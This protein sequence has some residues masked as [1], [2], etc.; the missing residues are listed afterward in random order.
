M[1]GDDD[2]SRRMVRIS[3][4]VATVS[5]DEKVK[6]VAAGTSN[7]SVGVNGVTTTCVV[8]VTGGNADH[9]NADSNGNNG[10]QQLQRFRF[11]PLL[12]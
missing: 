4:N 12:S 6:A 11:L 7:I 10:I 8:T 5:A 9:G 2:G 3:I 1:I